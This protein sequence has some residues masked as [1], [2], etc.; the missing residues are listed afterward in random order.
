MNKQEQGSLKKGLNKRHVFFI[1]IGSAIGTGLFYGSA[2]AIQLAGPAVLLAYLVAGAAVFIV[3]RALGEMVLHKPLAGSFGSYATM[4]LGPLAGFLTGWTYIFEMA[5]VCL[6]D[7]T[8]FATYMGFWYPDVSPWI[9]TLGVTLIITGLNLC[10]VRMFGEMEFLLSSIKVLAIIAMIV[11]GA[12]IVFFGY[13]SG[14]VSHEATGISNLWIHGG[15]FPKGIGGV[16]AALSV[17]MFAFGGIEIVGLTAAESQDMDNNIPRA[18]NTVP[19]R[20]LLFYIGTLAVLMSIFPWDQVGLS[21]SPFVRIFESLGIPYAPAILNVVVITASVSA[22]NSDMFGAARMMYGLSEDNQAPAAFGRVSKKGVP[23][24]PVL[25][26][27]TTLLIGVVLNYFIHDQLFFIIAAMAT[28]ATVWVWL[29]ILLS[30]FR[31]RVKMS[32]EERKAAKFPVPL[33]PYGPLLAIGFMIFT[34]VVLAFTQNGRT[35]LATGFIWVIGMTLCY[36]RFVRKQ[37]TADILPEVEDLS[38]G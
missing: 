35:A 16:I 23:L 30:H 31:M 21:G 2:G 10:A 19:S 25:T 14:G 22:I 12:V 15:F 4:Y 18:I 17:V 34:I 20:I 29:M 7:V 3:M 36:W 38:A 13:S 1:A 33:W 28:F 27:L 11:G 26:M 8:A 6:A 9:W 5:L 24:V 32:V 37:K